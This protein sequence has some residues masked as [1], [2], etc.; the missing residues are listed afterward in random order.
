M[1][2]AWTVLLAAADTSSG[3][4]EA[5]RHYRT[6][7]FVEGGRAENLT[8]DGLTSTDTLVAE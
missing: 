2:R 7:Q 4:L 1:G 6:S 5:R 3:G 8:L